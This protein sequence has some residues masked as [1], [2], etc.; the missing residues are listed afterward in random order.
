[1]R[2]NRGEWQAP[3]M[4]KQNNN[5]IQFRPRGEH[6]ICRR[7]ELARTKLEWSAE[8]SLMGYMPTDVQ[9]AFQEYFSSESPVG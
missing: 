8:M 9:E 1:M 2:S 5:V 7:L 6:S 4:T 3:P